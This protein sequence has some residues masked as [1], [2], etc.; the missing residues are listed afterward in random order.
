MIGD[1]FEN[2][3]RP[4]RG[5]GTCDWTAVERTPAGFRHHHFESEAAAW[6]FVHAHRA[7]VVLAQMQATAETVREAA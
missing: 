3:Q 5:N 2:R 4:H 1:P 7:A 6:A